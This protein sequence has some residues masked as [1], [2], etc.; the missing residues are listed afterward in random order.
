MSD[1]PTPLLEARG[2]VKRYGHVEALRG[3]SIDIRPGEV[4]ALIGDNGAGKS[5]FVKMLAGVAQPDSGE[6]VLRGEKV[7]FTRPTDAQSAGV[8]TV[9]QDLALALTLDAGSNVYLGRE[10]RRPGLLGRMGFVDRKQMRQR[11]GVEL[12]SLGIDLRDESVEVGSMSG[13]QRQAVAIARAAVWG[14][15]MIIM[16]EP[17]AALGVRQTELVLSLIR[18]IRDRGVAVLLVSHN[19]IDVL[20]V[21]DRVSV[22]RLGERI[23]CYDADKT[24]VKELTLTMAG[25][26]L[27]GADG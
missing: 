9:F 5:T 24:T 4:H 8:E 6:L 21:A 3:A 26:K 18:K 22:L 12:R 14:T 1:I 17:T 23:A 13:G 2:L 19:M 11:T 20:S 25:S 10:I 15:S 16:D 7:A 27:E